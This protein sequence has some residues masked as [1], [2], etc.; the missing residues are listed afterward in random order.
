MFKMSEIDGLQP[1]EIAGVLKR[2]QQVLAVRSA[3]DA[4]EYDAA[5]SVLTAGTLQS[6]SSLDQ[7][8]STT[9]PP[10]SSQRRGW[11]EKLTQL[12][13]ALREAKLLSD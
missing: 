13:S 7:L 9:I 8:F 3:I 4:S 10:V 1:H 11:Q 6:Y 12:R 2:W 5:P